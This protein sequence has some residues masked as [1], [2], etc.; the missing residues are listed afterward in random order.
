[1]SSEV[2]ARP[3]WWA[4]LFERN[5]VARGDLA[6]GITAALVLLAIE[7]SY[8]LV[9]FKPLGVEQGQIGFLIGVWTAAIA[10][11]VTFVLG[12][13]GP[14]LSGTSAAL[15]LLVPPLIAVLL[16]D[17]RFVT[18]DG[19]PFVPMVLAYVALG[20]VLAGLIQ[21][22]VAALRLGGLVRYVPYPVHAGY[23]NGSAVLMVAAMA[24]NFMGLPAG[25][26]WT[27]WELAKP[28][29]PLVAL[30]AFWVAVRPPRSLSLI[31]AYLLALGVATL[32]HH[33]LTFTPLAGALGPLFVPPSFA[34]PDAGILTPVVERLGEG[35]TR[36]HLGPLLVFALAVAMMSS[37]Q[38]ALAGSTVDELTRVRVN[39]EGALFGQGMANTALGLVGGVPSA[40]S[41]T[42]SKVNLEAGSRT[43]AS[44]LVFALT[45]VVLLV[46]GL[47]FMSIV[48]MAAIAG[49]FAA[50][51]YSLFDVWTRR[52]TKVMWVQSWRWRAPRSLAINYAVMLLVAGVTVF[53]S[54]PLAIALGT[55]VAMIMF[56][57]ANVKAP[58]RQVVHA[59]Q[60]SSRKV[61]PAEQTE[62]LRAHGRR[63]A[64]VEL[65][66]ALFFGTAEDA[67]EE[68][69]KLAHDAQI[70]ILDF[71]RVT[72]VD[73][74]GARV[75]LHAA[76]EVEH[77]G[78]ELLL[79]GLGPRDARTRLI[80][81][82]DVQGALSDGH[83]FADADRALEHAEDRL[84]A[85]LAPATARHRAL[86]LSETLLGAGLT[87]AEL[88]TLGAAMS[89]RCV[90]KGAAVFRRG[91]PG[92]ALYVSLEGQIG[93]WLMG[94]DPADP[95]LAR[96]LVSYAPGVA[97]GEIG[98]LEGRARSAD[99]IAEEDAVVLELA[100]ADYERL[101]AEQPALVGKLLLNLGLLL[102][103][104]VRALTNELESAHRAG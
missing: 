31:P 42:R 12:G 37:L 38:T 28:L 4:S 25:H 57:R 34:W 98:L 83:F 41:T 91:E 78:K 67:D 46:F 11:L 94:A 84:L 30:A 104:R 63:I 66:G 96:R 5:G 39:G 59:D 80:R 93:I 48:P 58:V 81:D 54:L 40:A 26:V 50:A 22:A 101:T 55:L 92:D 100:R 97:F 72:D 29:A 17:P 73:A 24:P 33:A 68:I 35:V 8:G 32:L 70:I 102:A 56:I 6:G 45:L 19:R 90:P 89:E 47:R 77:A 61:R 1:M 18:G 21:M 62:M 75:L 13:R 53:L 51:A 85:T 44:R 14:L 64:L 103:S 99:A 43:R 2:V 82:L 10:T 69:E 95:T 74:S 87:E 71:S 86:V 36:E 88:A 16:R 49:V 23:V 65:D 9:A 3:G 52:A 20:L 27:E 76:H 7:G 15:V 79:V 60:R